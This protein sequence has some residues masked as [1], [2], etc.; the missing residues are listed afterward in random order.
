MVVGFVK[1]VK[2]KK[3]ERILIKNYFKEFK[4]FVIGN[5]LLWE[6]VC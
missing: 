2:Y 6:L 5:R 3:G 4:E 1:T